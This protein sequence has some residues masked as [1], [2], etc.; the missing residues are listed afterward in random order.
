MT[1]WLVLEKLDQ[2]LLQFLLESLCVC[3]HPIFVI[4]FLNFIFVERL[5]LTLT[6]SSV[7]L[8]GREILGTVVGGISIFYWSFC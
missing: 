7:P 2:I 1:M 4:K 5:Y 8:E 3:T 6:P